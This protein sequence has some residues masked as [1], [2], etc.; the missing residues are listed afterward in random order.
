MEKNIAEQT[1][2]EESTAF[3]PYALT[4]ELDLVCD[5]WKILNEMQYIPFLAQHHYSRILP[6][7]R[8]IDC[9]TT[10]G[11]L[12]SYSYLYADKAKFNFQKKKKKKRPKCF[13]NAEL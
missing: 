4:K 6:I 9:S 8:Q 5:I 13:L 7:D 10:A 2:I 11:L 3:L 12:K 1:T